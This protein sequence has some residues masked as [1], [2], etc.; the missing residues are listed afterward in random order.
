MTIREKINAMPD[1]E[2]REVT[3]KLVEACRLE[4]AWK[5]GRVVAALRAFDPSP[6]ES[7][8]EALR[9]AGFEPARGSDFHR[10]PSVCIST[11]GTDCQYW[12]LKEVT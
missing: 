9:K 7:V 10:E 12:C 3:A 4:V 6:I 2:L 1:S 5:G 11:Y 8:Q